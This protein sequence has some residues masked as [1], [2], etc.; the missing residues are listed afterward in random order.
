MLSYALEPSKQLWT[1]ETEKYN[2]TNV[3][4]IVTFSVIFGATIG[5]MREKGK[6]LLL[7]F[8]S[9]SDAMMQITSW[10]IW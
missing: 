10:V 6:P 4:G 8:I 9:L 1:F 5:K 3:L 7:F 2:G